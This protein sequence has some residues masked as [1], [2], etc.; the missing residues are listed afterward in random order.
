MQNFITII[1]VVLNGQKNIDRTIHSVVEQDYSSIEY[2]V[3]DGGS[4]DGTIDIIR[5]YESK[6][7]CWVSEPDSGIA[8]AMNKGI[9]HSSGRYLL[10]LHSDDYLCSS[11]SIRLAVDKMQPRHCL[12]SFP[13]YY[14]NNGH[15]SIRHS[16]GFNTW[17]NFKTGFYHQ[18]VFFH[19]DIFTKLGMYDTS[20]RIAMDYEFFLRAYRAKESVRMH[21]RP[22]ITVMR[23]TGVSS[24]KDQDSLKKRFAEE[25]RAQFKHLKYDIMKYAYNIYWLNY[26]FYR[27]FRMAA[28]KSLN[29][30]NWD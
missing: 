11:S 24:Q 3:I 14:G 5:R 27:R 6:I 1:T 15:Y 2:I 21:P 8:D 25:K 23:D 18:G 20:F 13:I 22:P 29:S 12:H 26:N 10:F 19:R 9:L 30:E 28:E 7:S 17:I 16:R 4:T